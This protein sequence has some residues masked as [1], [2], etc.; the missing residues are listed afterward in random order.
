MPE[1]SAPQAA[2]EP[3]L[4]RVRIRG[5]AHGGEGVGTPEG[6]PGPVWFVPGTVP[7][8]HV[9]VVAER[10][11]ARYV[12]GRLHTVVEPGPDRVAEPC[13]K[14]GVCGGCNWQ[15]VDAARQAEHKRTIVAEQL[16]RV[17]PPERVELAFA[18]P[19]ER[20]RRRARMHY[21]RDGAQVR[22]GFLARHSHD[23]VDL[24]TCGVLEEAL[25]AGLQ[26][27]RHLG[28]VL[29]ERGEVLGLSDGVRVVLGLPG[30]RPSPAVE[31]AVLAVLDDLVVGIEVRG[32]RTRAAYG[33]RHLE[34]D[35]GADLAALR[36]GPFSFAQAQ[37]A[38]SRALVEHVVREARADELRVLE[39]FAGS[40][41]FTRALARR[42]SRVWASDGDR[43]ATDA[44]RNLAKAE[45]L[46]INAKKQSAGALLPKLAEA[47]E[48]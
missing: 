14:A 33:R 39:L 40:G 43:E 7:G 24:S 22:L 48:R 11:A 20:Y 4:T 16:R 25:D 28:A 31:H 2:P 13:P 44:L 9:D 21:L 30:V 23:V 42:A 5:F 17:C 45:G 41:N 29:P 18:G 46:P 35:G 38:G 32:G 6:A 47:R 15:H 27:V 26:R 1:S 34:I 12:R 19:A 37:A 8:D 10:A 36:V 3:A